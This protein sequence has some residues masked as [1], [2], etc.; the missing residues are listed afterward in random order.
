MFASISAAI[1]GLASTSTTSTGLLPTKASG[2]SSTLRQISGGAVTEELDDESEADGIALYEAE[3][4]RKEFSFGPDSAEALEAVVAL[5]EKL[6]RDGEHARACVVWRRAAETSTRIHGI[7]SASALENLYFYAAALAQA[8]EVSDAERSFSLLAEHLKSRFGETHPA[9]LRA[10]SGH[11]LALQV[12]KRL[13]CESPWSSHDRVCQHRT[14]VATQRRQLSMTHCYAIVLIS[15]RPHQV[16]PRM[17]QLLS[18]RC[19]A[20]Q[21]ASGGRGC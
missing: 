18:R 13:A 3:V 7:S 2:L 5:A 17:T 20:L 16:P 19:L 1:F 10:I 8:G 6:T 9:T 4:G 21:T 12:R 15:A 11:A 14:L